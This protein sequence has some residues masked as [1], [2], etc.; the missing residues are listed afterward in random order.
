MRLIAATSAAAGTLLVTLGV[1]QSDDRTAFSPHA[2]VPSAVHR[3]SASA[4]IPADASAADLNGVVQQYCVRCHSDARM[5][6]NLSLE[7]FDVE[8]SEE[9]AEVAERMIRKLRAGMMP[10][11]SAR[12]PGSDTLVVLAS[13]LEQAMDEAAES[14]PNPGSRVFQ[15]L[16]R[17]DYERSIMDLLGLHVDASE[18]LPADTRSA[19]FDNIADVQ[20]LSPTLMS[21][22]LNAASD[23]ARFA[24]GDPDAGEAESTYR[25]P[26]LVSQ[27]ERVEGAPY[28]SRG[29]VSTM[30]NFPAD[31]TYNFRVS[32]HHS[33]EGKL[34]GQNEPGEQVE[35]SID[36]ERVRLLPLD[37]FMAEEDPGGN[38]LVLETGPIPVRAGPHRVSAVF[39]PKERGPVD[40]LFSAHGNSIAD[41]QIGIGYGIRTLPHMRDLV[42]RGPKETFGVSETPVRRR[43]FTCRPLSPEEARPCAQSIVTRIATQAYRRPLEDVDLAGLMQFY[44]QGAEEGGFEA[45]VRRALEA[46]L[47]SPFFVFR[48]EDAPG[49]VG[50]G[51]IYELSDVALASRLSFFLWGAPPDEELLR[52]AERGDLSSEKEIRR[53][54]ERMLQDPRAEALGTRFAAQWLRLQDLEQLHP[55]VVLYPDYDLR[56]AAAMRR[57]TE[58]FFYNLVAEDRPIL[59]LLTADYTYANERLARH[60]GIPGVVGEDFRKVAYPTNQRRGILGHGSVLAQTSLANRTSPVNRGKWVSEVLLGAPPPPPPPDVPDLD[61]SAPD[62]GEGRMLSTRE[63]MEQHR[64]NPTCNSCHRLIDPI[65]L[66]LDNFDVV[67]QWRI[68]ENGVAVDPGGELYDGTPLAGPSDLTDAL[69]KYETPVLRNFTANLMAFALG[70]RVEYYDMPTIRQIVRSAE[71]HELRAS[72]FILGVVESEA[73]RMRRVAADVAQEFDENGSH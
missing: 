22:Y 70:R 26:R 32:F 24:I 3:S 25:I 31:G 72:S 69:V 16:N 59:E 39:I 50:P 38:G 15:R 11:S 8:R 67:G 45:G 54:A 30:H 56:L 7:T 14:R 23:V 68:R 4:D 52:I 2:E 60:Y 18:Y 57:E 42:I 51:E 65:G 43:I 46:T 37:R 10:P 28:G 29:G 44:D 48:F 49:D 19:N 9:Q 27:W 53:Q 36:G 17:A 47:A 64:Q 73:F 35:I 41:T 1:L 40:D 71:E 66:A 58:L 21:A 20:M 62:Q 55:D 5:R 33:P 6:G 12:R 63:R 61:E 34:Y 13:T